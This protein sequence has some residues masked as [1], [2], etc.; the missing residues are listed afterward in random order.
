MSVPLC[1][2]DDDSVPICSFPFSSK[3]ALAFSLLSLFSSAE[4]ATSSS[5]SDSV[6]GAFL[7]L[8]VILTLKRK[9]V[10]ICMRVNKKIEATRNCLIDK[11]KWRLR[12]LIH[13]SHL[14]LLFLWHISLASTLPRLFGRPRCPLGRTYSVFQWVNR[15]CTLNLNSWRYECQKNA[16]SHFHHEIITFWWKRKCISA[17]EWL[18]Q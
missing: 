16:I 5:S 9:G 6:G 13:F 15:N 1:W 10:Y 7:F 11:S 3:K 17:V 14:Y 12:L 18:T 4:S 8:L 2:A